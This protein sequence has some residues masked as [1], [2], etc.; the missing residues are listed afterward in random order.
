[1]NHTYRPAEKTVRPAGSLK[2]I[3]LDVDKGTSWRLWGASGSGNNIGY[4]LV[5]SSTFHS[6]H[7]LV[8]GR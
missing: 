5:G 2:K 3:Y 7:N 1:L 8:D 4:L 6:G